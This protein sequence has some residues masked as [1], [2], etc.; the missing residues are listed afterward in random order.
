M[1]NRLFTIVVL[2]FVLLVFTG[3]NDLFPSKKSSTKNQS[4]DVKQ[5]KS[6]PRV[7]GTVVA[8]VNN[9]VI[10]LEE[11]DNEIGRYNNSVPEEQADMRIT[12]K[13]EKIDYLKEEMVRRLLLYQEA[14]DRGLARDP[15]IQ[16]ALE[17]TKQ[18]LLVFQ[19]VQDVGENINVT[20][21]EI[22]EYYNQYKEQ[23]KD[24]EQRKVREIVVI[25]ESQAKDILIKLLQGEDFSTL[26]RMHSISS[27]AENGGDL[28][29]V[30][31]GDKFRKFDEVAF[32]DALEVGQVSNVFRGPDGYYILKL[33][34]VRG[35]QQKTLS[36]MRGEI[37][38]LLSF[39]KQQNKI[40]ELVGN[41]SSKVKIE[42]LED[43]ID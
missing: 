31:P 22:E 28:G 10:T 24:P 20:P 38:R 42:I 23:L 33:E 27:S 36:E 7:S 2:S 17:R 29:F 16:R 34:A 21:Q 41:I 32:S 4:R 13:E 3:C 9:H 19:L 1:N 30:A 35:G 8:K 25:S 18:Q 14:L 40:E 43:K 39:L 37:E 12:T 15:E 26:A 6:V 5:T 11:L